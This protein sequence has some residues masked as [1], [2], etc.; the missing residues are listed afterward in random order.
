MNGNSSN[1]QW[2]LKNEKISDSF[3]V[4]YENHFK[5]T[6]SHNYLL[7]LTEVKL[8]RRTNTTGDIK[9]STKTNFN[10]F[11]E[12]RLTIIKI[13]CDKNIKLIKLG[14]IQGFMI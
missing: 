4:D 8:F 10:L 12:E 1:V 2:L 13:I 3:L 14:G 6:M 9:A 11:M 7:M 5:Y